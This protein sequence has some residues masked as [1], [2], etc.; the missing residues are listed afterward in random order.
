MRDR[1]IPREEHIAKGAE[2]KS[3]IDDIL[4]DD[5]VLAP[6]IRFQVFGQG[7]LAA[8]GGG[9][10]VGSGPDEIY[11]NGA[12]YLPHQVGGEHE[13]ALQDR[14]QDDL[15]FIE[16]SGDCP[17]DPFHGF[18]DVRFVEELPQLPVHVYLA[19]LSRTISGSP[20]R[21]SFVT[22]IS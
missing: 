15:L 10:A 1:G 7:Y 21:L 4:D 12:S 11:D 19:C 2:S 18:P 5:H 8:C 13:S 14:H 3:R 9:G 20:G 22:S 16:I 6:Y 17:G